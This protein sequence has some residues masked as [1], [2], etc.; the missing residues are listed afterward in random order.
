MR[1]P[2]A[3]ILGFLTT[4]IGFGM[5]H[6]KSIRLILCDEILANSLAAL[7]YLLLGGISGFWLSVFATLHAVIALLRSR[8]ANNRC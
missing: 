5:V 1:F 8:K 4:I 6:L 3:H 7:T 2:I